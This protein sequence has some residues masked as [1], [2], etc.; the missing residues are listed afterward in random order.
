MLPRLQRPGMKLRRSRAVRIIAELSAA[1]FNAIE[2]QQ[3][4]AV[5]RNGNHSIRHTLRQRKYTAKI[6]MEVDSDVVRANLNP[7]S[8][9]IFHFLCSLICLF[10]YGK[11][12]FIIALSAT[13]STV[14]LDNPL[15]VNIPFFLFCRKKIYFLFFSY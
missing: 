14:L 13:I 1:Q 11:S 3:K 2:I 8:S 5:G 10:L 7:V 12:F 15:Y 6:S 4:I 9:L